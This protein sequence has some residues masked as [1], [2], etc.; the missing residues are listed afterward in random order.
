MGKVTLVGAGPGDVSLLTVRGREKLRQCDAVVY[1]R[2]ASEE[3]LRETPR[4]C[5]R[6]YV[7]KESGA[8]TYSQEEIN[9]ILIEC[10]GK[11]RHVVRLKGGDPFVFGRGGEELAALRAAG[12]SCETV[13]G[14]TSAVAVPELSGIPVTHRGLARSFHVITGHTGDT[15]GQTAHMDAAGQEACGD[16][17]VAA[18]APTGALAAEDYRNLAKLNGTL[19]FL[20]GLA[21]LRHIA[22]QLIRYG[23]SPDT[24]AAVIEKGATPQA[25]TLRGT[26]CDIAGRV[27][28]AGVTAPAV[29]VIGPVAEFALAREA[30]PVYAVGTAPTLEAFRAH[31]EARGG[32]LV[33]LIEMQAAACEQ[34]PLLVRELER[35]SDYDWIFL[36][37]KQAVEQFFSAFAEAEADIRSLGGCRF[38][39]IGPGTG[40]A[41]RGRGI[42][43]DFIPD[44][45]D[46]EHFGRE[47]VRRFGAEKPRVLLPRAVRGNPVLGEILSAAGC[48][49]CELAVY[50]VT[51]RKMCESD[52][53]TEDARIAFFSAS[54]VEAFF[55]ALSAGEYQPPARGR[56]YCIGRQTREA[57]LAALTADESASAGAGGVSG[58]RIVTA[59]EPVSAGAGGASRARIVTAEEPTAAALAQI[60][61][62]D[63][64]NQERPRE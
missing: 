15:G 31:I 51:P 40:E 14:I 63:V 4:D 53:L 62:E 41:L 52:R 23:K 44:V 18:A 17:D 25:R 12:I 42:H 54:G 37:S 33:P 24:P 10:A 22:E 3:L 38:A 60:M 19:I 35:I 55:A 59:E 46:A 36:T 9:R 20:M 39:A 7:G 29:I 45:A 61:M 1:D 57:L 34:M 21:N 30:V 48:A 28:G 5:V 27:R 8:H 13:P 16:V 43:A 11:Y 64:Q 26:L 56:F 6:I 50:D 58:A 2:L 47:F 49:V 32:S